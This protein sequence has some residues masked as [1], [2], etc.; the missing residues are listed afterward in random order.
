[1][2]R[3]EDAVIARF[4]KMGEKFEILVDPNLAMDFKH[5]RPVDFGDL[6]AID[7]VFKDAHKGEVKGDDSLKKVFSTTDFTSVAKRILLD[8]EIQ[9][10]TQQRRDIA[11][12]KKR[13]LITFI[14][15]NAMNPQTGSP[16]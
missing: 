3:T 1:M 8:G 5:G 9:L 6:I 13:E 4:E 14:S 11:E 16:N 7:S 12:Q 10:T 2:V 15:R